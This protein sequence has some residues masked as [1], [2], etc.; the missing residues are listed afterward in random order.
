M[1]IYIYYIYIDRY[2]DIDIFERNVGCGGCRN[3]R[4]QVCKNIKVPDTSDSFTA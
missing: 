4:C 2:I 3:G 1:C